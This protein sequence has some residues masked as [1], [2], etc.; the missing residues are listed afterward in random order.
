M[1]QSV[2]QEFRYFQKRSES[3]LFVYLAGLRGCS[4]SS[5]RPD[6]AILT[7]CEDAQPPQSGPTLVPQQW[8]DAEN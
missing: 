5:T 7:G 6:S 4:G 2:M 1:S 8:T 3:F